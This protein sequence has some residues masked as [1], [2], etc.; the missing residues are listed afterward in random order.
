M[1]IQNC[2]LRFFTESATLQQYIGDLPFFRSG[3]QDLL[4]FLIREAR[5]APFDPKGAGGGKHSFSHEGG[6]HFS[7][8]GGGKRSS[9]S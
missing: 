1:I 2:C 8:K 9:C 7:H 6:A 3:S 5:S 4:I